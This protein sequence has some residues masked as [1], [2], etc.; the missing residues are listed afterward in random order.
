MFRAA[1]FAWVFIGIE[2]ADTASLKEARKGQNLQEDTLVAVRRIYAHGIDVLAGFI[3]G[4][5]NDTPAT[6]DVQQ[7]LIVESGIS[8]AMV[9]LLTALPRTPLHARLAREQRLIADADDTN[10]T[11]LGTNV[12]P[13]R[14][15]YAAMIDGYRALYQR[16][17]SD[18]GIA[19]RVRNK[20]R[21]LRD[22]VYHGE[23]ST[24]ERFGIVLRLLIRGVLPGGPRRVWHFLRSLPLRSPAKMPLVVVDW[25][26]GLAMRDYVRRHFSVRVDAPRAMLAEAAERLRTA[27]RAYA[28]RGAALVSV[29][30]AAAALPRVTVSIGGALDRAFFV[31][32]ARHVDRLLKRTPSSLTLRIDALS[33]ADAFRF[34]RLLRR[35]APHGDRISIVLHERVRSLV[36]VDSSVF[37]VVLSGRAAAAGPA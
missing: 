22:P 28:E 30:A 13:K 1:N 19:D 17:T 6:F 4:F 8:A 16:L 5:D 24:P 33:A 15:A 32:L 35:L 31:R 27:L 34:Q 14:M 20:M 36:R 21:H 12:I 37:H 10:N 9:G 25:I 29:D 7:R 18:R 2:S 11:R 3:V 23:Y 26:A